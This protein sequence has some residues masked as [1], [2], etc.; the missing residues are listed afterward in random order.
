MTLQPYKFQILAI[1]Q[2][3][4]EV[5]VVQAERV[6]SGPNGQ[7]VDVFG[8]K[9]LAAFAEGFE[10]QLAQANEPTPTNRA[11]RRARK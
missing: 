9:G 3:V 8:V 11:Q 2:E 1:C 7:P 10:A 4:D 5:G 6:V